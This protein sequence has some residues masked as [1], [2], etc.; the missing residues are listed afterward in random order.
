MR[1]FC[2]ACG[3]ALTYRANAHPD[4]V[5]VT[6]ASLRFASGAVGTVA[7]TCLL[8]RLHRAGVQVVA[9]GL[10]LELSET[11]LVVEVDGRRDGWTADGDA[12]PRPDREFVAAGRPISMEGTDG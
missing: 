6:V 10:S 3:T 8:P 5:D 12:R 11:E 4:Q 9:D 1:T 7:S 2:G